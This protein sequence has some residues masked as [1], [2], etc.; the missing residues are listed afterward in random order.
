MAF[1]SARHGRLSHTPLK[2]VGSL[3]RRISCD[4]ILLLAHFG[5]MKNLLSR[6][7]GNCPFQGFPPLHAFLITLSYTFFYSVLPSY[8]YMLPVFL[9]FSLS[10][11]SYICFW[12]SM[13]CFF[14]FLNFTLKWLSTGPLFL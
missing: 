6:A 10:H 4:L 1:A 3:L 5:P 13:S 8:T 7:L 14:S 9:L 12:L 11:F 2:N